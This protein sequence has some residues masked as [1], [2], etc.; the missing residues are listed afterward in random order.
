MEI[1]KAK[2]RT[3]GV[4]SFSV[5]WNIILFK[6]ENFYS[7]EKLRPPNHES[8]KEK[9]VCYSLAARLYVYAR[10]QRHAGEVPTTCVA[11]N[12]ANAMARRAH[13]LVY[14]ASFERHKKNRGYREKKKD[15]FI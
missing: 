13:T 6:G 8:N 15:M 4:R 10:D 7:S 2:T 12:Q 5:L 3:R 9:V 14:T 11:R 1:N